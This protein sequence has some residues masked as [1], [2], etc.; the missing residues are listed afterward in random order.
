MG[1]C[2][3]VM[4]HDG[5]TVG[6][7]AVAVGVSGQYVDVVQTSFRQMA[8]NGSE[9]QTQVVA[10]AAQVSQKNFLER[11]AGDVHEHFRCGHIGEVALMT[12]DA[13]F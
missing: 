11:V 6:K 4:S 13:L 1:V 2:L 7:F 12:A 3:M 8:A 5:L 9:R 10:F